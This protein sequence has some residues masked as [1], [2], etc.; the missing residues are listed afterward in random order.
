MFVPFVAGKSSVAA[1]A[2]SSPVEV[3]VPQHSVVP[4]PHLV[5]FVVPHFVVFVVPHSVVSVAV[6]RSVVSVVVPRSVES[7]V[8]PHFGVVLAVTQLFAVAAVAV[9]VVVVVDVEPGHFVVFV[10]SVV[11]VS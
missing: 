9:V 4:V 5:E 2:G 3:V 6:P 10:W 1:V 7:A 11:A 8:V